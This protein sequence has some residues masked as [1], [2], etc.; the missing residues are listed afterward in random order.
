MAQWS[1]RGKLAA[2][3]AV[4]F[5][6]IIVLSGIDALRDAAARKTRHVERELASAEIASSQYRQLLE[7]SRRLLMSACGDEAVS[8]SAVPEPAPADVQRCD[9]YTSPCG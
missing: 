8:A 1:L 6:P 3:L 2:I 4:T 9:D 5:L 7:G